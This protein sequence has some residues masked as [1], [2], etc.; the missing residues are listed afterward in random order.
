MHHTGGEGALRYHHIP[1]DFIFLVQQDNL[2]LLALQPREQRHIVLGNVTAG[3]KLYQ[4]TPLTCQ[5][6]SPQLKSCLDLAGLCRPDTLHLTQFVDA[7]ATYRLKVLVKGRE[8]TPC[9]VNRR[10]TT[11]MVPGA[12][13]NSEQLRI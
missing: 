3:A 13:H 2:E 5:T 10:G 12:Q 6:P 4:P 7:G 1:D 8:K 9:Q 11:G